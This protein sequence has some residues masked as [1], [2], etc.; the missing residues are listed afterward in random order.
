MSEQVGPSRAANCAP[1]AE[2][3]RK[4]VG[5]AQLAVSAVGMLIM[6]GSLCRGR[7]LEAGVTFLVTVGILEI[8]FQ[9]ALALFHDRSGGATAQRP[10]M[11]RET[12]RP[13]AAGE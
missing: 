3:R 11:R 5:K 1:P 6:L 2:G 4:V 12:P 7:L 10:A 9:R 13:A 8:M